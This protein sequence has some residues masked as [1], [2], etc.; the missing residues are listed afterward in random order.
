MSK[1][2]R[3]GKK[4]LTTKLYTAACA[5]AASTSQEVYLPDRFTNTITPEDN[6]HNIYMS[7][8]GMKESQNGF[9]YHDVTFQ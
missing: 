9:N 7:Y 8:N 6:I 1:T 4:Y 2:N 3:D 5:D